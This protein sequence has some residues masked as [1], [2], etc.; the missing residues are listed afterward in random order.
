MR[1]ED[2]IKNISEIT[3]QDKSEITKF[4]DAFLETIEDCI[5]HEFE[6][7]IRNFGAFKIKLRQPKIGRNPKYPKQQIIIPLRTCLVKPPEL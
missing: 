1:K 4:L 5:R 6:V 2:I 7:E 3:N